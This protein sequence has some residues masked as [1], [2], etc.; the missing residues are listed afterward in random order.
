MRDNIVIS[1]YRSVLL[2]LIHF[3]LL[4]QVARQPFFFVAKNL[5]SS[6]LC[7]APTDVAPTDV[8]PTDVTPTE[9]L[10]IVSFRVT[11]RSNSFEYN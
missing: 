11:Y 10:T 6:Q 8:A 7:Y 9:P 5:F 1:R 4:N 3:V 2:H